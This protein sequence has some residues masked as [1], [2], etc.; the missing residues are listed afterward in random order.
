MLEPISDV[1][2]CGSLRHSSM[3]FSENVVVAKMS[4]QIFEILSF[5]DQERALPPSTEINVPTK[6]NVVLIVILV[7]K[8]TCKTL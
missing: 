2:K 6:L 4:Y 3:S 8:S 5:S 1:G 7:L